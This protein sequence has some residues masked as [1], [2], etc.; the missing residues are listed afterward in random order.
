M[1]A[2]P[3][4]SCDRTRDLV[5]S[6]LDGRLHDLERRFLDAHLL[7]CPDCQAFADETRWFTDVMRSAE[8]LRPSVPITLPRRRR[9]VQLRTVA[10]AA[11]AAIVLVLAGNVAVTAAPVTNDAERA[12]VA[13]SMGSSLLVGES[14][15]SLRRGDVV[16]GRLSFGTPPGR[17]NIGA[18][19][20]LVPVG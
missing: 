1:R 3:R 7:R 2:T 16:S 11:A 12:L 5:S 13:P 15:R 17:S 9:G 8:P 14:I 6:A 18:V 20:P 19:K 4:I 10:S